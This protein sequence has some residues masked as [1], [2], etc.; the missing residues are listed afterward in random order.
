[1]KIPRDKK[2]QILADKE[3]LSIHQLSKKYNLPVFEIKKIIKAAE[4]KSPPK[5]RS[6]G[7][8][9]EDSHKWFYAVLI[10]LPIIFLIK[11]PVGEPMSSLKYASKVNFTSSAVNATPSCQVTPSLRCTVHDF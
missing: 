10:S 2:K 6:E 9:T 1:L 4:K 7:L 3:H 11:A 8:L 5:G